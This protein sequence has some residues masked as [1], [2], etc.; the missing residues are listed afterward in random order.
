MSDSNFKRP[1]LFF[2]GTS[3]GKT[4]LNRFHSSF[5]IYT[6]SG[7]TLFDCGDGISKA[8]LTRN[9]DITLID[10]IIVTHFHADHICGLPSLLTQMKMR[11]RVIPL[12]IFTYKNETEN[13]KEFINY[14]YLFINRLPYEVVISG[15]ERDRSFVSGGEMEIIS[16]PNTHLNKYKQE[17][18]SGKLSFYCSSFLIRTNNKKIHY[19][20]D[21]GSSDDL[22][23]F[24]EENPNIIIS[25]Y[26]H[27]NSADLIDL[28]HSVRADIILT[29]YHDDAP[30]ALTQQL[31]NEF[32]SLKN[33]IRFAA[34]GDL[35][36]L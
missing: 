32:P 16:R 28:A 6:N 34:D 36:E 22:Y 18:R 24:E 15:Y 19:T 31:K 25:E 17:D 26:A 20:G 2:T 23:L 14:T 11:G 4:S 35:I 10:N 29:H 12:T 8:L 21:I 7:I 1:G 33:R 30:A 3:S 5:L 13:L 9:T 27:I